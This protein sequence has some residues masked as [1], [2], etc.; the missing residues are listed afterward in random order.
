MIHFKISLK[1]HF[2]PQLADK[3][4]TKLFSFKIIVAHVLFL[5]LSYLALDLHET[6]KCFSAV[7]A[8]SVELKE[9]PWNLK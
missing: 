4:D 7:W 1:K 6:P 9:H 8:E 3:H 5:P 2:P